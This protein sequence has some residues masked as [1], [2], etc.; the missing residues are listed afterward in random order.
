MSQEQKSAFIEWIATNIFLPLVPLGLKILI[1]LFTNIEVSILDSIELMLYSFFIS[2]ILTNM[3]SNQ[4]GYAKI[5]HMFFT[6]VCYV[7]IFIMALIY[8]GVGNNGCH[9]YAL[10]MAILTP[11]FAFSYKRKQ[12]KNNKEVE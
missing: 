10:A 12:I 1:R 8:I 11:I 3:T 9:N 7:D 6:I 5:P 2:I 4:E